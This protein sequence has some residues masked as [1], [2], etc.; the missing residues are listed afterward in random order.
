MP[1]FSGEQDRLQIKEPLFIFNLN[2]SVNMKNRKLTIYRKEG[3]SIKVMV[4]TITY[5]AGKK[6]RKQMEQRHRRQRKNTR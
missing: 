6:P 2:T 5:K 1:Q 4:K 3:E